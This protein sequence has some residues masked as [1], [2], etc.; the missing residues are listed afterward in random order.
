MKIIA[1]YLPQF[2]TFPEN[3]KWWGNGFTEWTN[4]KRGKPNFTGHYQP[5]TPLNGNY[6][7]LVKDENVLPEQIRLAKDYGVDG[8]CF[9][10]SWF[11]QGKKLMEKPMTCWIPVSLPLIRNIRMI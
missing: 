11:A 2:H 7:D 9:Y 3:D 8:F 4:T 1:F 5:H 6:Y 10:H